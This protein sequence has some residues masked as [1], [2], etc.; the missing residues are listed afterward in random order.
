MVAYSYSL[1]LCLTCRWHFQMPLILYNSVH[2]LSNAGLGM[3]MFSL[4]KYF[5]FAHNWQI[6][7]TFPSFALFQQ[8]IVVAL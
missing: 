8:L 2:I 7:K 5:S 4:G 3:A 1:V 6:E